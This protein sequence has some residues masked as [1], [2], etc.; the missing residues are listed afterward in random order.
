MP[1]IPLNRL[2]NYNGVFTDLMDGKIIIYVH[3]GETA[4]EIALDEDSVQAVQ[5]A[6]KLID[7][8]LSK[9]L[10]LTGTITRKIVPQTSLVEETKV[11]QIDVQ[12]DQT[13]L[14]AMMLEVANKPKMQVI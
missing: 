4:E 12:P 3:N 6:R 7:D 5:M 8:L 1:V 10:I 2:F 14:D 11:T 13:D 9:D